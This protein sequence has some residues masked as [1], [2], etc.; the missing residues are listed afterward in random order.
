[1][2]KSTCWK[3]AERSWKCLITEMNE[4]L[5]SQLIPKREWSPLAK[6]GVNIPLI[7]PSSR[8][9]DAVGIGRG[10]IPWGIKAFRG[11]RVVWLLWLEFEGSKWLDIGE[12]S[13]GKWQYFLF[14]YSYCKQKGIKQVR[15]SALY[16]GSRVGKLD[17]LLSTYIISP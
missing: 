2:P 13:A 4:E 9:H 16:F 3:Q 10:L 11:A 17:N 15:N 12:N 8:S 6:A 7:A 5:F 1:M 14:Y